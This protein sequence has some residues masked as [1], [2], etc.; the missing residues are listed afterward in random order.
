MK[1][2]LKIAICLS[3]LC[4]SFVGFAQDSTK[5]SS[6]NFDFGADL[7]SR[8]VWRGTQFGGASPALQPG[9]SIGIGGLEIG[10]W[11]SYSLGGV[12]PAQEFD[13]YV[14]YTFADMITVTL[15]DYFFPVEGVDY[16]YFNYKEEETGHILEAS[17]SFNGTENFPISLLLAMNFYGADAKKI[18]DDQNSAD[19]NQ[20]DGIQYSTYAEIGYSTSINEVGIDAFMGFALN[21]PKE[22]DANTGYIGEAGFYGNG[23]GVVNLGLTASKEVKITDKYSLPLSASIITN[24][25]AEKVFFV[26]GITF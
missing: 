4:L 19:F 15:N 18:N 21:S 7:V 1:R 24:P 5:T 10:T 12:N 8:Y 11:G 23:F 22:A 14:S 20:E 9:A 2:T 16:K 17:V 3:F 13:L 26:F 25:Q 6:V